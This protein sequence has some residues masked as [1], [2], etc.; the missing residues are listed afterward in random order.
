MVSIS[1]NIATTSEHDLSPAG[2]VMGV[3]SGGSSGDH[4][5]VTEGMITKGDFA[6][7]EY[8]A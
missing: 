1:V 2:E 7:E 8:K 4:P 6:Q 3:S 5:L